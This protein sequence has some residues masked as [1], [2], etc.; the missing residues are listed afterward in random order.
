MT[1]SKFASE[2]LDQGRDVIAK[3][4]FVADTESRKFIVEKG[5]LLIEYGF[6]VEEDDNGGLELSMYE[7]SCA[8]LGEGE[9][10]IV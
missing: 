10:K 6:S 7:E 8:T 3:V 1:I 2:L 9:W 4:S 5:T